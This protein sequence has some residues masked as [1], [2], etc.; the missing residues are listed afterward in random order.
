[1]INPGRGSQT[2][3][4]KRHRPDVQRP[5][6]PAILPLFEEFYLEAVRLQSDLD[7]LAPELAFAPASAQEIQKI[8][9]KLLRNQQSNAERSETTLG[10]EM[11]HQ[12]QNVMACLADEIFSTRFRPRGVAW[13]SLESEL[14]GPQKITGFAAGSVCLQKLE[15]LLPQD[16]PA[17]RELAA[18][19]FYALSLRPGRPRDTDKYLAPLFETIHGGEPSALAN[20]SPLF[21]QSYA[22]TLAENKATPLPSPKNWLLVLGCIL[23]TWIV[24]TSLLWSELSTPILRELHE[25]QRQMGL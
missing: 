19:Y 11:Y 18:V 5:E 1:V 14:F 15:L 4:I 22:H 16:N 25:I 21:A 3:S 9:L 6:E 7:C 20:A 24:L 8:L 2:A 23:L 10:A 13:T 12:A 17:Y